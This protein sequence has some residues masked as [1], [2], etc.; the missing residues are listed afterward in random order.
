MR[1]A[2][3]SLLLQRPVLLRWSWEPLQGRTRIGGWGC[4]CHGP[5]FLSFRREVT[6]NPQVELLFP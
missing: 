3:L 6:L 5:L 1:L 4:C 2:W